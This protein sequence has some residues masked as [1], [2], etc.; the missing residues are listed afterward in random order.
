MCAHVGDGIE[1]FPGD[2]ID[3][4]EVGDL[5]TGQ[6]VLLD[7]AH[8]GLD[9]PLLV[10]GAD[11]AGCDRKAVVAGE[12]DVAGIEHWRLAAQAPQHRGFEVVDHDPRRHPCA[13]RLEGVQVAAEEVFERLRDGEL[14]I[15]HAAV[16]E[17]QDEEAQ[18]PARVADVHRSV[19]APVHLGALAGLEV[20]GQEG[21][22]RFRPHLLHVLA[23]DADAARVPGIPQ[24]LE[25][26]RAAVRVVLEPLPDERLVGIELARSRRRLARPERRF[27]EPV[28]DRARVQRQAPGDLRDVERL[29]LV[30]MMD[31]AVSGVVDH[32]AALG[33]RNRSASRRGPW[34][35]RTAG[36]SAV[37]G[38]SSDST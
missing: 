35:R 36:R 14:H 27:V 37:A 18:L 9:P 24:A 5:K 6:E 11:V 21:R 28:A 23:H 34:S 10:T 22:R 25:D 8:P 12:V 38:R 4:A 30:Q 29:G 17:Y 3:E 20:Q 31:A 32:E 7:V 1:P 2:R 19:M 33:S 15:H 16:A 26:L 13:E